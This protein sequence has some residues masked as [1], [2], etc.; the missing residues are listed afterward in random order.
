MGTG[1]LSWRTVQVRD[2]WIYGFEKLG[3]SASLEEK[4]EKE[5]RKKTKRST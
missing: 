4:K 1:F 5:K 2:G 3:M